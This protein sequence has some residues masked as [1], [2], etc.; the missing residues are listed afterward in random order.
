MIELTQEQ[1]VAYL[2]GELKMGKVSSPSEPDGIF[3]SMEEKRQ[4]LE[5]IYENSNSNE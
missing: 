4:I 5:W 3:Y 1:L 2:R